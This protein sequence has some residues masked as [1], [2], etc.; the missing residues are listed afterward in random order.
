MESDRRDALTIAADPVFAPGRIKIDVMG[1][2]AMR[3]SGSWRSSSAG[4]PDPAA[5]EQQAQQRHPG[6]DELVECE[7]RQEGQGN[8]REIE[9]RAIPQH[10]HEQKR[11]SAKA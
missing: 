9:R 4:A 6:N 1:G 7:G 8:G 5:V 3:I 2:R 11:E 10:R